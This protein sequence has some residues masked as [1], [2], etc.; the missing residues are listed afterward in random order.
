MHK[1]HL[2][3]DL[4]NLFL[5]KQGAIQGILA[6]GNF[7]GAAVRDAR[8]NQ[9]QPLFAHLSA[10]GTLLPR[11][12]ADLIP[13]EERQGRPAIQV[14]EGRMEP[15]VRSQLFISLVAELEDLLAELARMV[16]LAFPLKAKKKS[17]PA[18]AA[19]LLE[20]NL[21]GDV[22]N[23]IIASELHDL[24]YEGPAKIRQRIEEII[25]AHDILS[26][27]WPKYMEMRARRD[28]GLHAGWKS[29]QVYRD[30]AR[31]HSAPETTKWL[32]PDDNYFQQACSL[33]AEM[34]DALR[35]H[36]EVKFEICTP[37]MVFKEMWIKSPLNRV[38][39]YEDAWGTGSMP[40]PKT[41]ML[42]WG[43]SGSERLLVDF[44]KYIYYGTGSY[45]V[46]DIFERWPGS[47]SQVVRAWLERPFYL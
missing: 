11:Q 32:H 46:G 25:S 26:P 10:A 37:K 24:F 4:N 28:I 1:A 44:F 12:L 42:E 35:S 29:N 33:G 16:L 5:Q 8:S 40:L 17:I 39:S 9:T 36:C 13:V 23:K 38:M 31:E 21:Y 15:F 6:V 3:S 30:K 34:C 22:L 14:V 18:T 7:I 47:R 20:A 43:W 2:A 19:S 41:E 27:V 45:N